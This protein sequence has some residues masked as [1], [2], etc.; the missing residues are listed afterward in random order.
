MAG[1]GSDPSRLDSTNPSFDHTRG[2]YPYA[3]SESD[4]DHNEVMQAVDDDASHFRNTHY[5][6]WLTYDRAGVFDQSAPGTP[7]KVPSPQGPSP[8]LR[9]PQARRVPVPSLD[10]DPFADHTAQTDA[11]ATPSSPSST[12]S[13]PIPSRGRTLDNMYGIYTEDEPVVQ[14][15]PYRVT[16]PPVQARQFAQPQSAMVGH[17]V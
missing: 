9:A 12:Y 14:H 3:R 6:E 2:A 13:R 1:V 5:E 17:A 10:P 16:P 15:L 4:D 7:A 11:Q 8:K